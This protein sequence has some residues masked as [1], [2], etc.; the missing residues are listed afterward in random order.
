MP[1][2]VKSSQNG[3]VFSVS[4]ARQTELLL[5]AAD[6]SRQLTP[7][8]F[9]FLSR[10]DSYGLK[11]NYTPSE[12]W[13]FGGDVHRVNYQQPQRTGPIV[14]LDISTLRVF[15]T[16]QWTEH[17]TASVNVSY[18]LEH[19][20]TPIIGVDSTGVS[21]ELSRQFDWKKFQ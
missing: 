10:Q 21:V 16:W 11:A 15:G 14:D 9:V 4:L 5:L 18:V 12:R 7:T 19:F 3:S 2:A 1:I 20:A 8:G 13:T 6:A 17:W